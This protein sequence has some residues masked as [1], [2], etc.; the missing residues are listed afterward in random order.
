MIFRKYKIYHSIIY[1]RYVTIYSYISKLTLFFNPVNIL[2]VWLNMYVTFVTS[3]WSSWF[4]LVI[5]INNT[6]LQSEDLLNDIV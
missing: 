3:W 6:Y 1:T 2:Y 5:N 4:E